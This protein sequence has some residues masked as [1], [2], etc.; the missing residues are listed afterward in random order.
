MQRAVRARVLVG[1]GLREVDHV[2]PEPAGA[3]AGPFGD[4]QV[5]THGHAG[6][7]LDALEGTGE[8]EPGPPVDRHARDVVTR[9]T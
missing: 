2:L 4:E 8:A 1:G 5:V 9:R 7:E 3:E 6:E